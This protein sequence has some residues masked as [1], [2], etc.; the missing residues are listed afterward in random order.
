MLTKIWS[1]ANYGLKAVEIEIE[2]NVADKGFPTFTVVGLASKAAE[3]AKERVKT[4]ILNSD[5]EF[6]VARITVNFAPA[7]LHKDGS[8]FDLPLAIGILASQRQINLPKEKSYFFGELGLD[9]TLRHT[10][11]VFLLAILAKENGVKNIFVPRECANEAAVIEGINVFPV[12]NLTEVVNHLNGIRSITPLITI[13]VDD[14]ETLSPEFDF[15]EILGQDFAKRALEIA[16]AGGHNVFMVGPPGSG[17]TMLSR[18]IPGI[19]P[20]LSEDESL[21]VTKIYSITGN[22]PAGGSLIHQRP[23]RC[24]HHTTSQV[25]LIGGGSNP[26]PGEISMAHRGVLFLDEFPEFGRGSLEALRQ[27]LEDGYITV[28]RASGSM[29]FPAQIMLI[30]ACNPCPC[31]F[32]GDTKKECKCNIHQIS[33]YQKKL[34]GPVMD[35]IDIHLTVPAVDVNKLMVDKDKYTGE[36]SATI[37]AR[38]IKSREIQKVR[39]KGLKSVHSNADMKNKH[40]KDFA[41]LT[42]SAN[43]LL[44]QAV[45]KFSLSA[46]TY[47]RLIK[48]SRTI[49]DLDNSEVIDNNHIA[50]ALQFRVMSAD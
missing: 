10:R 7:D 42:D 38:V 23:F 21:E 35:R 50:E 25:G 37:R 20:K 32:L 41:K 39:F 29:V 12:L 14:D 9:G 27:P 16:A 26:H 18:A 44:K 48:V 31:G 8:F 19:L 43:L 1:A 36:K 30:A 3:E 40:L 4:A 28:S 22:I 17:K 5:F 13:A 11:G 24:P 33:N 15:A 47:F 2:V 46:R 45:N 34:S 49:A 6:P